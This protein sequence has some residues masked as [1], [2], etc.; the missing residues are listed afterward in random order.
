L[1]AEEKRA[2][3]AAVSKPRQDCRILDTTDAEFSALADLLS[4]R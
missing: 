4:F 2:N 3:G 1:P